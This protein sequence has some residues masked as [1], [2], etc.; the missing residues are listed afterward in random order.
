M[1]AHAV[2]VFGAVVLFAPSVLPQAAPSKTESLHDLS[3]SFE[4]LAAGVRPAVV[5]IFSTGYV[6][7]EDTEST[8][9]SSLLSTQRSTG[10]GVILT[11]DG[12]IVT[13]NHVVQGARK[14]EVRLAS[15]NRQQAREAMIPA[16]LVGTDHDTDLAVI[17]VER[18]GL[19]YLALGD[20]N[21]LRQ[22]QLVMAFG[23]PLGLEGSASMGIVSSVARRLHAEDSM[24]YVQ[25]DAPINPGNSGGPL[26]DTEGRVV[27]I[28]TFILS[29]SGGSEGIGFAIPSNAVRNTYDQIRKDGHVHRGQIGILA[30]TIT[31]PMAKGLRLPQDWGVIAADVTPDGPADKAG[32]KAR[33]IIL[34]LNG[35]TME[36]GPQ[37]ETAIRRLKLT[38][39]VNLTILRDGQ[40]LDYVVAVIERDDDPQ[41]FA[42]MVNPEDNLVPKLG[43]LGIEINEKLSAMLGA[44]RHE[45]GVV[46]AARSPNPPYSG[47][48]LAPGD[49]IY[50]VNRTPVVSIKALRATL[51][52]LK[53]GDPAVLQVER[54]GKLMYI[55]AEFE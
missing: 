35:R 34:T 26:V 48:A 9:A 33:D 12:Y 14:I 19:P 42:D 52:A 29:Q 7:S 10:S 49:V 5:Q 1:R 2:S 6:A 45:Y 32:L 54:N 53:S 27:G 36:D 43:I 28:N 17:K 15:A 47:G 51:G 25:T 46:V 22:G 55:T 8:S 24:V 3:N 37:L 13:N 20:S 38:E 23:N 41:R 21:D 31:E 11:A 50:E 30:Q 40:K 16:T 4:T 18:T 39:T 44:L